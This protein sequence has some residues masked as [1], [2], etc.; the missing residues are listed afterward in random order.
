MLANLYEREKDYQQAEFYYKEALKRNPEFVL[1]ANNLAFLYADKGDSKNI[2]EAKKLIE[3]VLKKYPKEATF[4]DTAGWVYYR[5]KQYDKAISHLKKAIQIAPSAPTYHYH[6][7]M[8]YKAKGNLNLAKKE[9]K[10]AIESKRNFRE[11]SLAMETYKEI[12]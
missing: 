10:K 12:R 7:G 3:K 11:K 6:L 1:A 5:L 8:V 4:W 2:K 9:L